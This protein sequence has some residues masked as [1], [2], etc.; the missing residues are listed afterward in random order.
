MKETIEVRKMDLP[1]CIG[2]G[3]IVPY[4]GRDWR[5]KDQR[6]GQNEN[7]VKFLASTWILES[8][9]SITETEIKQ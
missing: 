7:V 4:K 9:S 8:V 3:D 2:I 6:Y 5:I 1:L